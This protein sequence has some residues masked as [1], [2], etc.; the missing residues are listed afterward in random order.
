MS[1]TIRNPRELFPVVSCV[2]GEVAFEGR[3]LVLVPL[4]SEPGDDYPRP[5]LELVQ[6]AVH[7]VHA[8]GEEACARFVGDF[9]GLVVHS[10]CRWVLRLDE[11]RCLIPVVVECIWWLEIVAG[12]TGYCCWCCWILLLCTA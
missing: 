8:V 6:D 12:A 2:V 1:Q 5:V 10:S 3:L 11:G 4:A 7:T 9:G